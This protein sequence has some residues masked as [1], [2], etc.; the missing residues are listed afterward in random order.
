MCPVLPS[1]TPGRRGWPV[2][3]RRAAAQLGGGR[4]RACRRYASA[5]TGVAHGRSDDTPTAGI[6]R[7]LAA[8]AAD[9][10]G[11][12]RRCRRDLDRRHSPFASCIWRGVW[13][14]TRTSSGDA[15]TTATHRARDVATFS[16]LSEYRN[17]MPRGASSGRRGR[18]RV[19]RR[20][21]PPGPGTCRPCRR[22]PRRAPRAR[23]P[24]GSPPTW[25]LYGATI[26]MS[27]SAIGAVAPFAVGPRR[28][29]VEQL[30]RR[31]RR[32]RRPPRPIRRVAR[33]RDRQLAQPGRRQQARRRRA[34]G[35][36]GRRRPRRPS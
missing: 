31:A 29:A 9:G 14:A 30:A 10:R 33:V 26:T 20:S 13:Q 22:G 24:A 4:V 36:R 18:H 1:A 32:S 35:A 28:A 11:R 12:R 27:S 6:A 25:A 8:A 23:A 5:A 15:T 2:A 7:A 19:D 34:P 3:R 21:A 17:S 16:R